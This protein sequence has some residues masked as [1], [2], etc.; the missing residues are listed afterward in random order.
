MNGKKEHEVFGKALDAHIAAVVRVLERYK[1]FLDKVDD[2]S[3]VRVL[4]NCIIVEAEQHHALLCAMIQLLKK[5]EGN[6]ADEFR[7]ARNEIAFW[8]P[9]LRQYEQRIAADCLYLKSQACW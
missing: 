6:G 2:A 8:T 3:P 9:G 7:M 5:Q 4:L 1:A